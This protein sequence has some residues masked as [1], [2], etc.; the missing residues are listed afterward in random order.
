[1]K[2]YYFVLLCAVSA[3]FLVGCGSRNNQVGILTPEQYKAYC[4]KEGIT[5]PDSLA[6]PELLKR[7]EILSDTIYSKVVV[8]DNR[9]VLTVDRDYFVDRGLPPIYYDLTIYS[10]RET[11]DGFKRMVKEGIIPREQAN[12]EELFE[13]AKKEFWANKK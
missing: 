12:V 9:M 3:C 4:E 13:Q 11:N 2:S 6:T 10:L 5:T 7:K 8:R 1:M